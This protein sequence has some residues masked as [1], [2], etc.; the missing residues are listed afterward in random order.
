MQQG[1]QRFYCQQVPSRHFLSRD[2]PKY[3]HIYHHVPNPLAASTLVVV[4][5]NAALVL[6]TSTQRDLNAT[7]LSATFLSRFLSPL[8]APLPSSVCTLCP[9][10]LR[11]PPSL[12]DHSPGL[13]V[14]RIPTQHPQGVHMNESCARLSGPRTCEK[15][16]FSTPLPGLAS[17]VDVRS[18]LSTWLGPL[19]PTPAAFDY[20]PCD[21]VWHES[22]L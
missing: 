14:D 10:S 22:R 19:M 5:V 20:A 9:P 3:S 12:P 7:D 13:L 18:S 8:P 11:L 2:S 17:L 6:G 1:G 15:D 4:M 16:F 21:Q